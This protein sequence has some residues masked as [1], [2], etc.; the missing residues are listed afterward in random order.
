VHRLPTLALGALLSVA[1]AGPGH[2]ELAAWDQTKVTA[3]AKQL[4]ENAKALYDT[5]YKQ[6]PP[7]AASGQSQEYRRLKQEVRRVK[8]E[9]KELARSLER[10]EGH[11]DT[12][13]IY[14]QLMLEV[15]DARQMAARVFTTQ[16][17]QQRAAAVRQGLNEIAPYYDP[18]AVPLQPVGR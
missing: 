2:A 8:A 14:E 4:E 10:G 1:L 17:V 18:D 11:D 9:A 3:L 16:D 7:S 15:R 12:L 5:F 6:P 13:P